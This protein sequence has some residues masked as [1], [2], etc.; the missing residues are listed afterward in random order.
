MLVKGTLV[1]R[2][3]WWWWRWHWLSELFGG[4]GDGIDY[5]CVDVVLVV[6][7]ALVRLADRLVE[8]TLV[9][10]VVWCWWRGHW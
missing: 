2:V 8:V 10:G 1:I 7:G 5:R 3:I 6:E 9:I 4:G